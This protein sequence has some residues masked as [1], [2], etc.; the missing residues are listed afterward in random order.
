MK[1]QKRKSCNYIVSFTLIELLVVIAIIAILAGMLLPALNKARERARSSTC[2]S[3]LHQIGTAI[4]AYTAD[5][6][7]Y[8]PVTHTDWNSQ[9][10]RH[11]D[12][13]LGYKLPCMA[14]KVMLCP[15]EIK[16]STVDEDE[17]PKYTK[18]YPLGQG[19]NSTP[20]AR[21]S[22]Y[23]GYRPN[24][25][26]GFYNGAGNSWNRA[27]KLHKMLY[28]SSYVTVAEKGDYGLYPRFTWHTND[29]SLGIDIHEGKTN[30]CHGDGS[31][32]SI[33]IKSTDVT[34][35]DTKWTMLFYIDGKSLEFPGTGF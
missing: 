20:S 8:L 3:N 6:E 34:S 7:E 19:A 24:V 1:I 13:Y 10:V 22:Y 33:A 5:N 23:W 18:V 11:L 25:D 21:W 26:N 31:A 17:F 35:S 30:V 12:G 2:I 32:E 28:P 16:I 14:P 15:N 9:L 27:R 4:V 29:K